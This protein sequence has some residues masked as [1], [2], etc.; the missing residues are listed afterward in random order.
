[1]LINLGRNLGKLDMKYE[2]NSGRP[3]INN[4]VEL[5]V[6]L[7]TAKMPQI[8][9]KQIAANTKNSERSILG[10]VKMIKTIHRKFII[11]MKSMKMILVAE[12]NF[13]KQ[14]MLM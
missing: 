9:P 4:N 8:N 3:L 11:Y 7:N 10:V 13:V 1:M 12:C 2:A 5:D 14:Y 6:S